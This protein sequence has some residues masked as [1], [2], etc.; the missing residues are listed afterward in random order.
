MNG[1]VQG[2]WGY[3]AAAYIISILVL[4]GYGLRTFVLAL[5]N[6]DER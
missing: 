5:R 4:G 6:Y 1:L 2:G 3:V